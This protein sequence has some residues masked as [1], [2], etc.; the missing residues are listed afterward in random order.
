MS[1]MDYPMSLRFRTFGVAYE[2]HPSEMAPFSECMSQCARK[3]LDPADI[4]R[5]EIFHHLRLQVSCHADTIAPGGMAD[6]LEND[7]F[8]R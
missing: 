1:A 2:L 6:F 8:R 4:V 5:D 3:I 7:G